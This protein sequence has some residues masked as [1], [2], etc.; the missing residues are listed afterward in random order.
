VRLIAYKT[1]S[2]RICEFRWQLEAAGRHVSVRSDVIKI[3]KSATVNYIRLQHFTR[4]NSDF[5]K[6]PHVCG[7][8]KAHEAPPDPSRLGRTPPQS[9]P[10]RRLQRSASV[11]PR[12]KSWLRPRVM[13]DNYATKLQQLHRWRIR[14]LRHYVSSGHVA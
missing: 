9:S 3:C 14:C 5:R 7:R 2:L 4:F 12:V 8:W 13:L 6:H 1:V 10:P 11:P